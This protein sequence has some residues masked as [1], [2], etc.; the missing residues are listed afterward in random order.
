MDWTLAPTS[1]SRTVGATPRIDSGTFLSPQADVKRLNI[2]LG[3][4]WDFMS[5]ARIAGFL[6]VLIALSALAP[7]A[8]AGQAATG[9]PVSV[10]VTADSPSAGLASQATVRSMGGTVGLQ[11]PVI[12]GYVARIPSAAISHLAATRG[13]RSVTRNG[14][15]Q[16][17]GQWDD[18]SSQALVG[19][20]DPV[21]DPGSMY[22]N[23]LISGARAYWANGYTGAG[24]DIALIDSGIAPVVGLAGAA[25]VLN[26]PDLSFETNALNLRYLDTYG[27]GTH[28]ASIMAGRDGL[29]GTVSA[30]DTTS[31]LGVAPN[32][33]VLSVKV[34]DATG[35]TDVSQIIAAISWVVAH[36]NDPGV[37]VRVI[38]LSFGLESN[39]DYTLDP[40]AYAAEQAWLQGIVVVVSA[41]N[42]GFD[43]TKKSTITNPARDP[44]VIAVGAADTHG[45]PAYTDDEVVGFSSRT[46]A[47]ARRT[48]D[49]VAPGRSIQGLRVPGAFIDRQYPD[50][51]L[52]DRFF[53]GSGT[54]QAAAMV[55]G[56]AAL[57]I[58]Q[59]PSIT[60][61]QLKRLLMDSTT[62][63]PG[64]DVGSQGA[65]E[66]NLTRALA[67]ATPTYEQTFDRS[68]GR[69][70]LETTR[71][72]HHLVNGDVALDGERD[73]F[74][75]VWDSTR[76]ANRQAKG[77]VW[78]GGM[79]NGNI[80][81]GEAWNGTVW[82][83]VIWSGNS[84][85][86]NSWS[87]N[88]WSG[89]SWSGNS[90]SGNSWSGTAWS[91]NSWSSNAWAGTMWA[92]ARWK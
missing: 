50:A 31:F 78:V 3:V 28:M 76:I 10:V 86:G 15:V 83:C 67:M 92:T 2:S 68:T 88:S 7:A 59:R 22:N 53:R 29:P 17:L 72:G 11:L 62:V 49:L 43:G 6:G 85:S 44:Y 70:L 66:L 57:I 13:I 9:S 48:I 64:L 47:S 36:R 34:A 32:A 61:D 8:T 40:L 51:R 54:S 33:R 1:W 12:N 41:G 81:S 69:G 20:Y 84:W 56:A 52:T 77:T 18:K 37:N 63:L 89:N 58:S 24:V 16:L 42:A 14:R 90:W 80:W 39:Q 71:A 45:T 87:G 73:I 27:H 82:T 19:P 23:T 75:A 30:S 65:G 74:G 26:G 79:F 38:N 55:S 35:A 46:I 91:G 60:P 21:T 25:D 4:S 5:Q